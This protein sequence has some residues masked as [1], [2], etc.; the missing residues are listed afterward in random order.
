MSS[1]PEVSLL[2]ATA[3]ATEDLH[4]V[5]D[6]YFPSSPEDRLSRLRDESSSVLKLL[7]SIPPGNYSR[8]NGREASSMIPFVIFESDGVESPS[9]G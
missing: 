4:R 9:F 8:F 6:T 5:Q 7:D 2:T 1:Q 3:E